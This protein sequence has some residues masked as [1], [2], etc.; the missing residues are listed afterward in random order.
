MQMSPELASPGSILLLPKRNTL[1]PP[2]P[3]LDG[4]NKKPKKKSDTSSRVPSLKACLFLE[5]IKGLEALDGH[6]RNSL[7][8]P[9]SGPTT[10]AK[11]NKAF[12]FGKS[13]KASQT[14][15]GH[16]VLSQRKESE[17]ESLQQTQPPSEPALTGWE[18]GRRACTGRG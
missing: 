14:A 15:A 12:L 2:S 9:L 13:W 1:R 6:E 18:S 10:A 3:P 8:K 7:C 11:K 5:K 17:G 4:T 16:G